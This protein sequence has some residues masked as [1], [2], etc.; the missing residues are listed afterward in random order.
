MFRK[1]M[2]VLALTISAA[3]PLAA[4]DIVPL[5]SPGQAAEGVFQRSKMEAE[6]RRQR[7]AEAAE[8][9]DA[10]ADIAAR[11]K[12]ACDNRPAYRRQ[13]GADHPKMQKLDAFCKEAGY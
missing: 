6:A 3:A 7:E 13:Y 1:T 2:A 8:A 5:I 10:E 11:Q 9:R 4:Q 12:Q